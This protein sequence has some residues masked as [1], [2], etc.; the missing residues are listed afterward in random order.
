MT[1]LCCVEQLCQL[2]ISIQCLMRESGGEI[3]QGGA[4]PDVQDDVSSV[5]G[6]RDGCTTCIKFARPL[7]SSE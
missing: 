7:V 3:T 4:C 5:S 6:F 1:S 2:F